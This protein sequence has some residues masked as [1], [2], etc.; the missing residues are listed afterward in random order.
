[1]RSFS[2]FT[3]GPVKKMRM[4]KLKKKK[5]KAKKK[6]VKTPVLNIGRCTNNSKKKALPK[7][8]TEQE[9][10]AHS[11]SST[12]ATRY[13]NM[14]KVFKLWL[15][16]ANARKPDT[17]PL[18]KDICKDGTIEQLNSILGA[19]LTWRFNNTCN[20]GATLMN[21]V[22]GILYGFALENIHLNAA[23][24]PSIHRICRG[25]DNI[26]KKYCDIDA[27]QGKRAL[28]YPILTAM[29]NK[30]SF[31]KG[32]NLL[33]ATKFC[34]RAQHYVFDSKLAVGSYNAVKRSQVHFEFDKNNN[35]LA[36]SIINERDKNHKNAHYMQRTRFCECHTAW[37]CVVHLGL[38][39]F[40][41]FPKNIGNDSTF[42]R[43]ENGDPCTYKYALSTIKEAC[44]LVGIDPQYYGTHSCRIGGVSEFFL[45]G[46][47]ASWIR[48]FAYWKNIKSV[49]I[50]IKPNN[51]DLDLF[52]S[53]V[54]QYTLLRQNDT[55][56]PD[57]SAHNKGLEFFLELHKKNQ[58]LYA[59]EKMRTKFIKLFYKDGWNN[60]R[61]LPGIETPKEKSEEIIN[62]NKRKKSLPK[63]K[64]VLVVPKK[65]K[66]NM[67]RTATAGILI[68]QA[69]QK[70]RR[71]PKLQK[72]RPRL[73]MPDVH[74]YT[75]Y[76]A[77]DFYAC[78]DLVKP[79]PII[80]G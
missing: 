68:K 34:L 33:F 69:R 64:T 2:V 62:V 49:L 18:F 65:R 20:A 78:P 38:K 19:Y 77:K 44:S 54:A 31:I 39:Y 4:K 79:V 43:K 66:A 1:M 46:K 67:S 12:V 73:P 51:P 24:L 40:L 28:L 7:F 63:A 47:R 42:I 52:V 48:S 16:E 76:S 57:E 13:T 30:L 58:T 45:E 55:S 17:Y 23:A 59:K 10:V 25:A 41:M 35:P 5:P 74:S 6:P 22:C 36:M 61:F 14:T 37:P 50:Y 9:L 29:M 11:V 8:F 27:K 70:G 75:E 32:F 80:L 21:H 15:V 71:E 72:Q 3:M 56:S 53:S 26:L 60:T